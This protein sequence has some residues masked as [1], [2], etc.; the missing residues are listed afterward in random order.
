VTSLQQYSLLWLLNNMDTVK[1][2]I[3][4][5][6]SLPAD[7]SVGIDEGGAYLKTSPVSGDVSLSY[8]LGGVTEITETKSPP[9][10]EGYA[11]DQWLGEMQTGKTAL[12]YA[13]WCEE[14]LSWLAI[15]EP[16]YSV[17]VGNVGVVYEGDSFS[18]AVE[19]YFHY[20]SLSAEAVGR[21]AGESVTLATAEGCGKTYYG[22]RD[23][24]F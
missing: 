3:T 24:P 15:S 11:F 2:L 18:E 7:A 19:S 20:A 10:D 14:S 6:G 5:L 23:E 13:E 4:W 12:S 8:E 17:T 22:T 16:K 1:N 21:V 9:A